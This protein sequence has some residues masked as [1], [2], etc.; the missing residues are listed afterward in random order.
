MREE[1][2]HERRNYS[3][4]PC[5]PGTGR[6]T[7]GEV[8]WLLPELERPEELSGPRSAKPQQVSCTLDRLM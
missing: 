8:R 3:L 6:K 1:S 4:Q 5:S 2:Q 7:P